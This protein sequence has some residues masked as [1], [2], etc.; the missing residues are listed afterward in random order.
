MGLKEIGGLSRMCA[1]LYEAAAS[2]MATV[3]LH[4]MLKDFNVEAAAY[5]DHEK[6]LMLSSIS[7]GPAPRRWSIAR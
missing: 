4:R 5:C 3:E 7:R 1:E 2:P 6:H